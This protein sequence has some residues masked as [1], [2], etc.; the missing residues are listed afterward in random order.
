MKTLLLQAIGFILLSTV[1]GESSKKFLG[2]NW[3]GSLSS[4]QQVDDLVADLNQLWDELAPNQQETLELCVNPPYVYL[5]RVRQK[6]TKHIA[7]G[8]QNVYDATG[9]NH[10][11]TG[12]CTS[13]MLKSIGCEWVLL[14]HSDRRNALGETD[15]LIA[16]KVESALAAGLQVTLTIGETLEQRESG[17][18]L[19]TLEHQLQVAATRIP[20]DQAWDKVTLAYEPVWAIG[21]GATPCAPEEAQRIASSLRAWIHVN[22]GETAAKACR[23]TYTGS[24]NDSNA[25]DYANLADIDGFV[26]GRAGLD[27]EK[28]KT[29]ISALTP[30]PQ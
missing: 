16:S 1:S 21:D 15:E 18:A 17:K 6:L 7:V 14:G 10:A 4:I 9:P 22:I 13:G 26:V 25:S 11:H 29:I 5:D 12:A 2:A 3:K 8:S 23:I 20:S 27:A 24:V 30:A 28:L 19:E